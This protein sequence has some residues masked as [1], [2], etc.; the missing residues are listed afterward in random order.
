MNY[1]EQL[2]K[3]KRG[4]ARNATGCHDNGWEEQSV[5]V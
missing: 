1:D 4:E 3:N 5:R 2:E